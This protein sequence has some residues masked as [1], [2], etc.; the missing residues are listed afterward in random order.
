MTYF[1]FDAVVDLRLVRLLH[2]RSKPG[3]LSYHRWNPVV[4][5]RLV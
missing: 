1:Y 2:C 4:N 3:S 5:R